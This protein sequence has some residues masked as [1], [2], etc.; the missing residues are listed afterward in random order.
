MYQG[1][2]T[3]WPVFG[4]FNTWDGPASAFVAACGSSLRCPWDFLKPGKKFNRILPG[5]HHNSLNTLTS[6]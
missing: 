5:I 1:A 6:H 3:D 2:L 4:V